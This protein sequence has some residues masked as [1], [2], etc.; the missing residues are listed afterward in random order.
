MSD[1]TDLP[2]VPRPAQPVDPYGQPGAEPPP[3]FP[4][5]PEFTVGAAP[6]PAPPA[7]AAPAQ[8]AFAAPDPAFAAPDPAYTATP[9]PYP[10]TAAPPVSATPAYPPP[11]PPPAAPAVGYPVPAQPAYG[12]YGGYGTVPGGYYPAYVPQVK[13]NGMAIGSMSTAIVGAALLF[14]YGAGLPLGIIGAVLGHIARRQIRDKGEGGDG[15]AL[16]GIIIG[17]IVTGI[18]V[19]VGALL[20]WFFAWVA[21]LPPATGGSLD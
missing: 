13:T 2:P 20:I 4:P 5:P 12:G 21:T 9:V 18:G 8:P 7:F 15:M 6:V 10:L 3:A 17:W 16:A 14:C 19:V 1:S 11:Y